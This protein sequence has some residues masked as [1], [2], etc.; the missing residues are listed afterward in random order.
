M[1]QIHLRIAD[2][3]RQRKIT[4]Q[5]LADQVGVSYQTVSRWETG[6]GEPELSLLAVLAEYFQVSADQLLGLTPLEGEAYVPERT[7]TGD[8]WNQKREYLLRTRKGYYNEDYVEFLVRKVWK[9]EEPVS[10]LDCGCG[11]GYL[12]L[13]LMPYLAPGS[14]YTGIDFAGDLIATGRELY[15]ERGIEGEF[16]QEDVLAYRSRRQYDVVICQAVLRHLDDPEGFVRK[17]IQLAKPGGMV[18]CIDANREFECDGLY[19]D[20][21]DYQVL[22]RHDGLEKKV[23]DGARKAGQGLCGSHSHSPYHETAG[24]AGRGRADERPRRAGD[25]GH[26]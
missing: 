15:R 12:G 26:G 22:C 23:G 9:L 6:A 19:I 10:L 4:Q 21:M 13:L 16:I 25:A 11:Y 8:F 20:G 2:L 3:R 18:I 7:G 14:T 17:M 1:N 5:E 24:A